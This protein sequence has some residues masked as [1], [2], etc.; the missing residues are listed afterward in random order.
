MGVGKDVTN[1]ELGGFFKT[2]HCPKC[3]YNREHW[4]NCNGVDQV[5]QLFLFQD[6][7]SEI[8]NFSSEIGFLIIT[9]KLNVLFL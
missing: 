4:D 6:C 3:P 5:S 2:M 7:L 9:L 8:Q 1:G